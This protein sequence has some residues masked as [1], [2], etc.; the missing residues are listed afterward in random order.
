MRYVINSSL[1]L[2]NKIRVLIRNFFFSVY[3]WMHYIN[4]CTYHI[5][6][7]NIVHHNFYIQPR[8]RAN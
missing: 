4:D 8:I 1:K 3:L 2:V 6:Y 7:I 5:S